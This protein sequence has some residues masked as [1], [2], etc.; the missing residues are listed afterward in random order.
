MRWYDEDRGPVVARH[1]NVATFSSSRNH[2]KTAA[3]KR[4]YYVSHG[5]V[6]KATTQGVNSKDLRRACCF[7]HAVSASSSIAMNGLKSNSFGPFLP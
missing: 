1:G 3:L 6:R 7:C 4:P 5:R 2:M